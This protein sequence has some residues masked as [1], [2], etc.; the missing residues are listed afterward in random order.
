MIDGKETNFTYQNLYSN[1][2]LFDAKL[3]FD[4]IYENA[5]A[6][7]GDPNRITIGG[8]SAGAGIGI[9]HKSMG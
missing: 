9:G 1:L 4:F 2:A 7:G 6:F 8:A 5:E 3:A